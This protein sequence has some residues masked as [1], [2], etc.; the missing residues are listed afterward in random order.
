M[1]TKKYRD[2]ID[3][4]KFMSLFMAKNNPKIELNWIFFDRE[5]GAF[6]ATNTRML[7]VVTPKSIPASVI[8]DSVF[9]HFNTDGRDEYL[10]KRGIGFRHAQTYN[11]KNGK[12]SDL[13]RTYPD[14]TRTIPKGDHTL[15]VYSKSMWKTT[16]E[17]NI[18]LDVFGLESMR[19]ALSAIDVLGDGMVI[20]KNTDTNSSP[21]MYEVERNIRYGTEY[22]DYFE[23]L[24]QIVVMPLVLS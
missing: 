1:A 18:V 20:Y 5:A 9:P 3:F 7:V 14:W 11:G 12:Y 2:G 19:K 6:V 13:K 17:Q 15:R 10:D 24:I 23:A 21:I 16:M 22:G 8:Y 4:L